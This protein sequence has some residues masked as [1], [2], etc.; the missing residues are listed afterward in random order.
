M[1]RQAR[2]SRKDT[3][4]QATCPECWQ[5]VQVHDNQTYFAHGKLRDQGQDPT[6]C[7]LSTRPI[8]PLF[9]LGHCVITVGAVDALQ[10]ANQTPDA[11]LKRHHHGDWGELPPEDA[12][13]NVRGVQ[14]D[15]RLLS[16]YPLS[17]GETIWIITEWDRSVST[18][19]LPDEY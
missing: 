15:M 8:Q 4:Q 16:A 3:P 13:A 12:Q 9:A 19:L 7:S 6:W 10:R 17:T 11:L 18:L 14:Q 2:S 1:K 5:T